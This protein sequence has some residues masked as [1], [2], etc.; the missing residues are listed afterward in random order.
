MKVIVTDFIEDNLSLEEQSLSDEPIELEAFQ[1]KGAAPAELL[2]CV[3]H[4]DILIVNMAV[5]TAEVIDG[6]TRCKLIIR[7]GVGYD[8]VDVRAATEAGIPVM[9]IPDYCVREVAEQTVALLLSLG[10]RLPEQGTA[11]RRSIGSDRWVYDDVPAIHRLRGSTIG[12]IG[13]GRIGATVRKLLVGFDVD[14]LACDPYMEDEEKT[15]LRIE[16]TSLED[17]MK[18][19]D[20]VLVTTVLNERTHHMIGR[21]ALTLMKPSAYLINTSRGG[22]VDQGALA[23]ALWDGTIAGAAI[24][25]FEYSEPP[26]E[27][28]PLL[29]APNCILTPHMGWYSRQAALEIRYR[30]I[31][32]IRSFIRG[33]VPGNIV[34]PE[35]WPSCNSP[36]AGTSEPTRKTGMEKPEPVYAGFR[37]RTTKNR[38]ARRGNGVTPVRIGPSD[39]PTESG[40]SGNQFLLF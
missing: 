18:A 3:S 1:L 30:I 17:L 16:H 22:I 4:A 10:R 13:F 7:H 25:V 5:I 8:T 29:S 33:R 20:F 32:A 40:P 6:L 26:D 2:S 24:D 12:I 19:S 35:V 31:D 11:V 38:S 28:N 37:D 21:D 39:P 14:I 9:N 15:R 36:W 34:N 23:E 27:T